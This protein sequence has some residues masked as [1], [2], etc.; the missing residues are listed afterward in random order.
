MPDLAETG[1]VFVPAPADDG[2]H[3]LLATESAVDGAVVSGIGEDFSHRRTDRLGQFDEMRKHPRVVDVRCGGDRPKRGAVCQSNNVVFC[4]QLAAVCG[5]RT[6]EVS[7]VFG[8][9]TATVDDDGDRF[10][11]CGGAGPQRQ[12]QRAVDRAQRPVREPPADPSAQ[13]G[14]A[15]ESVGRGQSPPSDPFVDKVTE[16]LHDLRGFRPWM[17]RTDFFGIQSVN[18]VCDD[19]DG[20]RFYG[21]PSNRGSWS[22]LTWF[23]IHSVQVD[24]AVCRKLA[25]FGE[26]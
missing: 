19:S 16:G 12:N 4:S 11:R 2:V 24:L 1:A 9:H 3:A 5:I 23:F 20:R 22:V 14:A 8:S 13:G 10:D 6:N 7:A 25:H 17:A 26:L 15:N 21:L 18:Q